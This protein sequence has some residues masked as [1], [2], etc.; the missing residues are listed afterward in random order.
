MAGSTSLLFATDTIFDNT[1]SNMLFRN[2]CKL[3]IAVSTT[4]VSTTFF[5]TSLFVTLFFPTLFF[6]I[7]SFSTLFSFSTTTCIIFFF[8]LSICCFLVSILFSSISIS[9]SISSSFFSSFFS[10]SSILILFTSFIF[11]FPFIVSFTSVATPS[12]RGNDVNVS[13]L[14]DGDASRLSKS[15]NLLRGLVLDRLFSSLRRSLAESIAVL[16]CWFSSLPCRF[17]SASSRRSDAL[18]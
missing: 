2:V 11:L 1:S 7:T 10:F 4:S 15:S 16:T 14:A 17:S 18:Y 13:S 3:S 12:L 6:F 9:S 8:F 5:F